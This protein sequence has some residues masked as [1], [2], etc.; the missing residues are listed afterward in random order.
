M[1]FHLEVPISHKL[2]AFQ[3]KKKHIILN[4]G[5]RKTYQVYILY[6]QENII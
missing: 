5:N 1:N 6:F 4:Y 3:K 2:G